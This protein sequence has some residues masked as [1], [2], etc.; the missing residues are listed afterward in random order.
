MNESYSFAIDTINNETNA[1]VAGQFWYLIKKANERFRPSNFHWCLL[2]LFFREYIMLSSELHICFISIG[3]YLAIK[4]P[5]SHRKLTKKRV[6]YK[7]GLVWLLALIP[8]LPFIYMAIIT[9]LPRHRAL[10]SYMILHWPYNWIRVMAF[11][12]WI[13]TIGMMVV[14]FVFFILTNILLKNK[15]KQDFEMTG[16]G[17]SGLVRNVGG[18]TNDLSSNNKKLSLALPTEKKARKVVWLVSFAFIICLLPTMISGFLGNFFPGILS[19]A[20]KLALVIWLA[21]ITI[22]FNL[23]CVVNPIIYTIFNKTFREDFKNLILCRIKSIRS[24]NK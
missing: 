7:I 21:I 10:C 12:Q 6:I 14:V 2:Q 13:Y 15:S 1:T 11:L 9:E 20:P 8:Y 23:H 5:L 17:H 19:S 24:N 4:N 22:F 3:R 16:V 18:N